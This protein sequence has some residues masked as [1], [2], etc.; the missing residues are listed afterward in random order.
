MKTEDRVEA[1]AGDVSPEMDLRRTV[2]AIVVFYLVLLMLNAGGLHESV[3]RL[4]F[5]PARA[6]WLKITGPLA[7][8]A[9]ALKLD[10]PRELLKRSLGAKINQGLED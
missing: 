5:G 3:Q 8:G 6:F 9:G 1:G 7:R 4:P 2:L 10:R